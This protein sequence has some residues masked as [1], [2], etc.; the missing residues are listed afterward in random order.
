M[1]L[2]QLDTMLRLLRQNAPLAALA[3]FPTRTLPLC[4]A[5]AR[6]E[7]LLLPMPR[8]AV[9][10]LLVIHLRPNQAHVLDARQGCGLL[11]W[12]QFA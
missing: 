7:R 3:T 11:L 8:S 2:A 4:A 6:L 10:V 1:R 9:V 5:T 12:H